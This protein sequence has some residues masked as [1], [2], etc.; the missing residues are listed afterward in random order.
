MEPLV[1]EQI[2][3]VLDNPEL[4]ISEI[5]KQRQDINQLGVLE[6]ELKHIERQLKTLERDQEKLLQWALKGFPEETIVA[7]N[8]KINTRR[9]SLKRQRTE[10]ETQ[11]K[12][13]HDAVIS[14]PKLEQFIELIRGKLSTLDYDTK[15]L[16]LEMLNIKVGIDG[17]NIDITGTLPIIEDAIVTTQS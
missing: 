1:W 12:A 16:A 8:K 13:S 3:R 11:I 10:L 2:E 9:E 17:H 14:L 6:T 7:E 15:R 5:Q 4:I